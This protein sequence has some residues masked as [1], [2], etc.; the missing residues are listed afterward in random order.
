MNAIR[1]WWEG[2]QRCQC[3]HRLSEHI[4]GVIDTY[5][6]GRCLVTACGCGWFRERAKVRPVPVQ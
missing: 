2:R 6:G 4:R 5:E 1:T 3:R